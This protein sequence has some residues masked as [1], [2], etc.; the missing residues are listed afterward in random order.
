MDMLNIRARG[1]YARVLA[2]MSQRAQSIWEGANYVIALLA[3]GVIGVVWNT[4]RKNELPM[5]LLPPASASTPE[6]P[7]EEE[8]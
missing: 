7:K 2:P 8:A 1:S 6:Q 4:R 3:L 5:E